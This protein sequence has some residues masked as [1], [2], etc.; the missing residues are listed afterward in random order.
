MLL[1][2]LAQ[3]MEEPMI[4]VDVSVLQISLL[5]FLQERI[6]A[7]SVD[8]WQLQVHHITHFCAHA[9]HQGKHGIT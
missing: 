5:R 8:H 4:P 3:P 9:Q 1:V 6:T 7:L 2:T